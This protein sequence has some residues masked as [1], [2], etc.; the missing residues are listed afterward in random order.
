MAPAPT[1]VIHSET[2]MAALAAKLLPFLKPGRPLLLS[3]PIGAGK[4]HLARELIQSMAG[5]EEEVPS[6]TYTIVQIYSADG[7]EIWHADLYRIDDSSEV[8]ELGLD[9]ALDTA[10]VI[11]EWPDRLPND[12]V[13]KDAIIIDISPMGEDRE[14]RISGECASEIL[15]ALAVDA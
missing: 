4:T 1:I 7:I 11:I 6:P 9:D 8:I 14:V 12:L 13:P 15:K 3:G 10:I 2:E 5:D